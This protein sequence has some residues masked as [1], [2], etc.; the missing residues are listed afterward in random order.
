PGGARGA[1]ALLRRDGHA[2]A[3]AGYQIAGDRRVSAEGKIGGTVFLMASQGAQSE[4]CAPLHDPLPRGHGAARLCL[5]LLPSPRE[6]P[7]LAFGK[8]E[9][10]LREWR[11]GVGGGGRRLRGA[12]DVRSP[13]SRSKRSPPTPSA[14]ARRPRPTLPANGREGTGRACGNRN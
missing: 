10:R 12:S 5:V 3:G 1:V 6:P 7:G 13:Q 8:P 2:A 4:A 14:V 11:G 9:D